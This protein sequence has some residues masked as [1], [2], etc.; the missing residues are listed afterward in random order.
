MR[1]LIGIFLIALLCT[2]ND[3][4][5]SSASESTDPTNQGKSSS[6]MNYLIKT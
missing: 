1:Q 6:S 5:T 4:E 2:I 3:S